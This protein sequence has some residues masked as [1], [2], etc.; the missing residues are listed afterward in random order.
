MPTNHAIS[1]LAGK[2]DK[3]DNPQEP[4]SFGAFQSKFHSINPE[5][6]KIYLMNNEHMH[7]YQLFSTLDEWFNHQMEFVHS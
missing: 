6:Y 3:I 7:D 4:L 1:P 5:E 2:L